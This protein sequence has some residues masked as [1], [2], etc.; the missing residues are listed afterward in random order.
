[1]AA[2]DVFVVPWQVAYSCHWF[3]QFLVFFSTVVCAEWSPNLWLSRSFVLFSA[4]VP[5]LHVVSAVVSE[6]SKVTGNP[7]YVL[8]YGVSW[9]EETFRCRLHAWM[10]GVLSWDANFV[11]CFSVDLTLDDSSWRLCPVSLLRRPPG[12]MFLY[13]RVGRFKDSMQ[14][15][16]R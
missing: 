8:V 13:I 9:S 3:S 6:A 10:V 16:E 12:R 4:F 2:W 14:T 7:I 11:I 1:M 5:Y 15:V